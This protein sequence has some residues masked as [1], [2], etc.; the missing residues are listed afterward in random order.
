MQ[1]F[2][3]SANIQARHFGNTSPDLI[4]TGAFDV[5]LGF[6]STHKEV[7]A[8]CEIVNSFTVKYLLIFVQIVLWKMLC[9][10]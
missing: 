1:V 6:T 9:R 3:H 5:I 10:N 2:D 8:C 7:S 4:M